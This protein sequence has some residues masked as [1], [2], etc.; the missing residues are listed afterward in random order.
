MVI[1]DAGRVREA[2][3]AARGAIHVDVLWPIGR[4]IRMHLV[5]M[6]RIVAIV[7]VTVVI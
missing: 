3:G 2:I 4:A 6:D 1:A 7:V 5:M